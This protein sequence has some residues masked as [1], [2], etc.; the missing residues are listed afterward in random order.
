MAAADSALAGELGISSSIVLKFRREKMTLG[1]HWTQDA[2]GKVDFT[3]AGRVVVLQEL[4]APGSSETEKKEVAPLPLQ[5]VSRAFTLWTE[6]VQ[7][8]WPL[9]ILKVHANSHWVTVGTPDGSR[10]EVKVKTN[11]PLRKRVKLLCSRLA[12][13]RWECRHRGFAVKLPPLEQ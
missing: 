9:V 6:E 10:A 7:Q 2:A 3:S 4:G 5:C 13:G 1:V 8:D 12:D 11:R